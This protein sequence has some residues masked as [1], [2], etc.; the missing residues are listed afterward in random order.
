MIFTTSFCG[1]AAR[2]AFPSAELC[3]KTRPPRSRDCSYRLSIFRLTYTR[4]SPRL[5]S[6]RS[7]FRRLHRQAAARRDVRYALL[8][9]GQRNSLRRR[10]A[11]RSV[12]DRPLLEP[13]R[14]HCVCHLAFLLRNNPWL[15]LGHEKLLPVHLPFGRSSDQPLF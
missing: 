9:N 3:I 1:M 2:I 5:R 10:L 15:Q 14:G 13:G 12:N 11:L 4:P 7:P 8:V 6:R